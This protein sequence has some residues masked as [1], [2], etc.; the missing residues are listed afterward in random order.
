M[1]VYDAYKFV[2][3]VALAGKFSL[4]QTHKERDMQG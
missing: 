3:V 2:D 4:S 1:F